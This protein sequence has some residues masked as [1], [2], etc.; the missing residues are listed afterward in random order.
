MLK[1]TPVSRMSEGVEQI[2]VFLRAEE[3][4]MLREVCQETGVSM[5]HLARQLLV[6]WATSQNQNKSA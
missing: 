3:R 6:A 4:E 1:L 2:K 5:T